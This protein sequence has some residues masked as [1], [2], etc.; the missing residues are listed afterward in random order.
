MTHVRGHNGEPWNEMADSFA[1]AARSGCCVPGSRKELEKRII[2]FSESTG[3][4]CLGMCCDARRSVRSGRVF[5][6]SAESH[7]W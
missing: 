7:F 1:E 5:L 6:R 4:N 2:S 3:R